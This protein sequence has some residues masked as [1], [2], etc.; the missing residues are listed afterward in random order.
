MPY[1][2]GRR[3]RCGNRSRSRNRSRCGS[4]NRSLCGRRNRRHG[5]RC[6]AG[7]CSGCGGFVPSSG[8]VAPVADAVRSGMG[9]GPPLRTPA[10][11]EHPHGIAYTI[12]GSLIEQ[13]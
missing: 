2:H 3:S 13:R 8:G 7:P 1:R 9:R 4:R 12:S 10:P 6:R 5:S 11:V